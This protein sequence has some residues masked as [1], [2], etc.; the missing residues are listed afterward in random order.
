MKV[1]LTN[2]S[3]HR[4]TESRLRLNESARRF[5]IDNINSYDFETIRSTV[6]YTENKNILDAPKGVGYWLWKPYIILE[7]MRKL[8]EGDVVVYS[9]CG[10]ELIAPIDPLIRICKEEQ[11]VVLFA[12]GNLVNSMWTKRDCFIL[13]DCDHKK[14]WRANQCDAAF[15]LFRKS[16]QAIQFLNEWLQYGRDERIITGR[17]NTLGKKNLPDFIEHRW[18]QSI[19]S[20]LAAKHRFTYFRVPT[21]YGNHYKMPADRVGNEFN[22]VNQYHQQPAANYAKEPLLNSPYGQLLNHHRTKINTG[23]QQAVKKN[24]LTNLTARIKRKLY[25]G[26][27]WLD[28]RL[29]N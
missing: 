14:Y 12:N 19:L 11:P 15:S 24:L 2:L 6:F 9:D 17:P 22:Q 3:N 13:M 28:E 8:E 26:W 10:I 25:H 16:P 23:Q 7:T 18:D 27:V 4:F 1:T 20:L 21:Q 5:G 29:A